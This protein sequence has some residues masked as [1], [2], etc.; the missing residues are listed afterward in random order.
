MGN[1][2]LLPLGDP[3]TGSLSGNIEHDVE[4]RI[5]VNKEGKRFVNE[6]GRRDDM[7]NALFGQTDT[8]MFIVMDSRHLP[9]RR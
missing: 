2:Q 6:G 3:V 7:T 1:I 8:T 5:F 4:T 9:H